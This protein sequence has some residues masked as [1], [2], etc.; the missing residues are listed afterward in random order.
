M[1]PVVG[2]E[3]QGR[4]PL[5]QPFEVRTAKQDGH[6]VMAVQGE[7]DGATVGTLEA[8]LNGV[9]GPVVLDLAGVSFIDSM[10]LTLLLRAMN[11]GLTIREVSPEVRRLLKQCGL[12]N[13]LLYA[14]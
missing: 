10:G 13:E 12:E 9:T 1:E 2:I 3:D 5:P 4:R 14:G 11:D 7:L 6:S 8:Y